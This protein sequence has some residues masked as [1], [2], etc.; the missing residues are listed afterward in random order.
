MKVIYNSKSKT[1]LY[2]CND[3]G[4]PEVILL[5]VTGISSVTIRENIVHSGLGI[6]P[7]KTFQ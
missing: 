4:K 1:L 3:P 6:K 5:G 2:H 7:T